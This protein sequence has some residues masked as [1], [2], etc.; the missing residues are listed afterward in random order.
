MIYIID[1]TITYNS[2]DCTL[3]HLPTQE[4]LSLSI[5]SGRLFEQLLN[6]EGE[7]L[8]R[9]TLLTEVWDKYGLRGSNSNLNQ[10]LSILRRA[11]AAYGCENLII[12]IPKIGIRL[13]TD[14]PV[15]RVPAPA[16]NVA[17]V[18]TDDESPA[19]SAADEPVT[20]TVQPAPVT[21]V[22]RGHQSAA[23]LKIFIYLL[24]IAALL[25][26]AFWYYTAGRP[27]EQN[28]PM[29]T[30]KLEG[31]CE[32]VLVQG[33]DVIE[34]QLL[35]KQI[36][37]ILKENNQSCTPGRRIYFDKNNSFST[38]NFGRTIVS[39]CNL[40]SSGHIISCDNFYYLDW[41]IN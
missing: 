23:S 17:D 25:G 24:L 7:I 18:V 33:L 29:S 41:R 36:L 26:S 6:S 21:P 9:D 16:L 3:N 28:I 38:T 12:T 20:E 19:A 40:N 31:G 39:A 14:I 30:L 10:Y 27:A 11:L 8:S 1:S 13:N 4:S 5:S 32:A 34:R 22:Q 15:E 35:D 37:Q 2:D